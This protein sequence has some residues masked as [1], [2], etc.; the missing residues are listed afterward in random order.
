M[1]THQEMAGLYGE[2]N[3]V[4]PSEA[5]IDR[6]GLRS[7]DARV[8]RETGIPRSS[9]PFFSVLVEGGPAFLEVIDIP[10]PDGGNHREV[11]IGGPPGDPGFRFSVDARE[12]FV[13]LAQLRGTP[14]GEVVNRDLAEFVEFLYLIDLHQK[15]AMGSGDAASEFEKLSHHLRSLNPISFERPENWWSMALEYVA[16]E[17]GEG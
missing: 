7:V 13:T 11:V 4:R 2:G 6:L 5:E 9:P 16:S 17:E 15:R 8:L 1:I 3:L 10:L 14:R 12:G